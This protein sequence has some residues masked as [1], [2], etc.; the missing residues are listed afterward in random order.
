[1][2]RK[3]QQSDDGA[4]NNLFGSNGFSRWPPEVREAG[5]LR[6]DSIL[7]DTV[8]NYPGVPNASNLS[9]I[10]GGPLPYGSGIIKRRF[11]ANP[12]LQQACIDRGIWFVKNCSQ[13]TVEKSRYLWTHAPSE[14]KEA[15]RKRDMS[16]AGQQEETRT[17]LAEEKKERH[18]QNLRAM[19]EDLARRREPAQK[20]STFGTSDAPL[21]D[22]NPKECQIQP[23]NSKEEPKKET[24]PPRPKKKEGK[25]KKAKAAEPPPRKA[26]PKPKE[27]TQRISGAE[28]IRFVRD[29]LPGDFAQFLSSPQWQT[30]SAKV[31]KAAFARID[32]EIEQ[33]VDESEKL[34]FGCDM[35]NECAARLNYPPYIIHERLRTRRLQTASERKC[36]SMIRSFSDEEF[37]ELLGSKRL[38]NLPS[39]AEKAKEQRIDTII[40]AGIQSMDS[41]FA[42]KDLCH[43]EGGPLPY[44]IDLVRKRFRASQRVENAFYKKK[45]QS[46]RSDIK[47]PAL[48]PAKNI[49]GKGRS[50]AGSRLI[51][52][53]AG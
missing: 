41:L 7:L 35:T 30:S 49:P 13:D 18:I 33:I 15:I 37:N 51:K 36:A 22:A 45:M 29:A 47:D 3:I 44:S 9:S 21:E 52:S 8:K 28:R 23:T 26:D 31:R 4:F 50:G 16:I 38:N 2:I 25:P 43:N 14:V 10:K 46:S 48:N 32:A 19:E 20:K 34:P 6:L 53:T 12:K 1:M 27:E 40:I 39:L 17:R 42:L 24:P 5:I 11:E